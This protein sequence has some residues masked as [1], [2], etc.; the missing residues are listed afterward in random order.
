MSGKEWELR[1]H[2][3]VLGPAILKGYFTECIN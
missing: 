1:L 2:D 3:S